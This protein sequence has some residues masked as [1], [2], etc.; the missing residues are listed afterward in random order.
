MLGVALLDAN[1]MYEIMKSRNAFE[2]RR[3]G[4]GHEGDAAIRDKILPKI[5]HAVSQ[6]NHGS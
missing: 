1:Y 6:R 3:K 5:E 2:I 4:N